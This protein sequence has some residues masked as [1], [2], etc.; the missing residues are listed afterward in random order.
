[1]TFF[2]SYV[3]LVLVGFFGLLLTGCIEPYAPDVINANRS[4]LVVDGF[5][6]TVGPTTLILSRTYAI[7]SAAAPPVEPKASVYIEEEAGPRYSVREVKP[8]TYQ[9]DYLRLN[10]AKKYRLHLTTSAGKE[11]ASDYVPAQITPRF[12]NVSWRL[13]STGVDILV[14]THDATNAT[15]YY[16]W[17]YEE[18]WEIVPIVTTGLEYVNHKMQTI[19]VPYPLMCW[20]TQKSPDIK[21]SK[22]TNLSQDVVS[23]Y[24]LRSFPSTAERLRH[25]Y[26]I[27]VKQYAQTK[28]EY[29]YWDL[30]KKNTE[31]IGTLFDPLPSQLTGNIRCLNDNSEVAL[32]FVG[33]HSEEQQRIFISRDQLPDEWK[34]SSGYDNCIPLDT[35]DPKKIDATF[36]YPGNIPIAPA[37]S[38]FTISSIGCVDCRLRGSAVKPSFWP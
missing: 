19:R 33:A 24:V 18:T 17:Q 29:Q 34:V 10:P 20:G 37:G 13:T 11:Y 25:R 28:E 26:S 32:G 35:V 36:S 23:D 6:N 5:I 16:Q 2:S 38:S 1:M 9:S 31:S 22:T 12:D 7:S 3:R 14:N 4:Y 30:I 27:L 8:G 15:R 21:L